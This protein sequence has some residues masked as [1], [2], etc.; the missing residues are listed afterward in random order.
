[1]AMVARRVSRQEICASEKH[2]NA[3]QKKYESEEYL[4]VSNR[5]MDPD[6]CF[7]QYTGQRCPLTNEET[8]LMVR[9]TV[10]GM[11]TAAAA[12]A[13]AAAMVT[14]LTPTMMNQV[15]A[16]VSIKTGDCDDRDNFT[17]NGSGE[18]S[19][20]TGNNGPAE[21][22][23]AFKSARNRI[24]NMESL[25]ATEGKELMEQCNKNT[26]CDDTAQGKEHIIYCQLEHFFCRSYLIQLFNSTP[27]Q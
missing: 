2:L 21:L 27:T 9:T 23:E 8:L 19:I 22:Q 14:A 6:I 17:T 5:L 24:Y 3:A 15:S 7:V 4:T 18:F 25:S 12:A 10:M 26:I 1:M 11:G 20:E 16:I 13:P